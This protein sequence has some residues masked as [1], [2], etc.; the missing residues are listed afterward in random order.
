MTPEER[1]EF[2]AERKT[3]VGGS[4]VASL[5]NLGYGCRRRLWYDKSGVE[6]DYQH[7]QSDLMELGNLLE[8]FFRDKYA[9]HTGRTVKETGRKFGTFRHP[10]IPEIIVHVDGIIIDREKEEPGALEVK[11]VGNRVWWDVRH[12]GLPVDYI[13]QLQHGMTATMTDWGAYSIGNRD[14]GKMLPW[15]V[16]RDEQVCSNIEHEVP[17]FWKTIGDWEAIPAKLENPEDGR[18][19]RC[20]WRL[21]CRGD[22][23]IQIDGAAK[24]KKDFPEDESLRPLRAAFLERKGIESEVKDLVAEAHAQLVAA[25]GDREEVLVAGRPIYYR[26]QQAELMD[27]KALAKA[28]DALLSWARRLEC[29]EESVAEIKKAAEML[30]PSAGFKVKGKPFRALR[31]Y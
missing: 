3:G 9:R 27:D 25:L 31:V 17:I 5:W 7:D 13:M 14:S 19:Q 18:C 16:E 4:D 15:D 24:N 21:T 12:K 8:P 1:Q 11:S 23:F 28:Y 2:L 22:E 26:K 30:R 20:D 29:S 10:D 6:P